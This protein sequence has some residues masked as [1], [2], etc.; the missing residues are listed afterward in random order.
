V[1]VRDALLERVQDDREVASDFGTARRYSYTTSRLRDEETVTA[2]LEGE[3]IDPESVRSLD[4]EKVEAAVEE[5]DLDPEAVFAFE[6]GHRIR[7]TG[8]GTERRRAAFEELRPQ[9][10][11]LLDRL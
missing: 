6:E 9:V 10:R 5:T 2:A 11:A 8:A 7:R 4:A 3:G 1:Q